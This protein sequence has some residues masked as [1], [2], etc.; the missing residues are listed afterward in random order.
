V[1]CLKNE[2][3]EGGADM[4]KL[5][6]AMDH[7]WNG[8]A[9]LLQDQHDDKGWGHLGAAGVQGLQ[10]LPIIGSFVEPAS[11]LIDRAGN[12]SA[13]VGGRDAQFTT[14]GIATNYV[15]DVYGDRS[16]GARAG[17]GVRNALRGDAE[18]GSARDILART[19]GA[20]TSVALGPMNPFVQQLDVMGSTGSQIGEWAGNLLD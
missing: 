18:R 14:Q 16:T 7:V 8:G 15:R 2:L 9:R 17:E 19:A 5:G 4:G 13:R 20:H 12:S 11:D 10:A 3:L 1:L 6:D